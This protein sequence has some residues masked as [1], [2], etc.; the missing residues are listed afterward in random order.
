MKSESS[1]LVEWSMLAD[2]NTI[3]VV[4]FKVQY[5]QLK[6]R[7]RWETADDEIPAAARQFEVDGLRPGLLARPSSSDIWSIVVLLVS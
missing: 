4:L 5:Q 2:N 6:P 1:V 3:P 7:Q